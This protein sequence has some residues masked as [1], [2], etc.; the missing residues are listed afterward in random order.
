MPFGLKNAP[1][2]FSQKAVAIFKEF[3][4]KFLEVYLDDW[5]VISLLKEL[6]Q[7]LW[8]ML[9]RF[10][11]LQI[12]LNFRKCIFYTPF[13]TLLGHVMCKYGLMV[14]QDKITTILGMVSPTSVQEMRATLGH[15][16]Y[17]RQFIHNYGKIATP[18]ENLF[19]KDTKYIWTPECYTTKD[20]LKEKLFTALI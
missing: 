16:G 3:I 2:I 14:D 9:D 1:T 12:S 11:Q 7:A 8:L 5:T 20:T 13:D 19:C 18:L 15:T 10:H 17:Y 6:M 4:H